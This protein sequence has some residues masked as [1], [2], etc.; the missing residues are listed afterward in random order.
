MFMRIFVQELYMIVSGIKRGL[1]CEEILDKYV[2]EDTLPEKKITISKTTKGYL[3]F[4]FI[5]AFIYS[6]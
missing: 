6:L 2:I 3:K 1:T 4:N 5:Y